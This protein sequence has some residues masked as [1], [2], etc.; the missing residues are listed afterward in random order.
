M[1]QALEFSFQFEMHSES[2]G[3]L[4]LLGKAQNNEQFIKHLLSCISLADDH[5]INALI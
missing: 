4:R 3:A 1:K 2:F 5:K